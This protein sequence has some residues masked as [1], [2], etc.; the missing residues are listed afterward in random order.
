MFDVMARGEFPSIILKKLLNHID[1]ILCALILVES[2]P[3][4][5]MMPIG[6]SLKPVCQTHLCLVDDTCYQV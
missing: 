2:E 4:T 5:L 6:V 3:P 1:F